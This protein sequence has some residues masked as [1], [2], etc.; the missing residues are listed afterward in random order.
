MNK[1]AV[2]EATLE[3]LKIILKLNSDLF[4]SDFIHDDQLNLDWTYKEGKESFEKRIKDEDK[5]VLVAEIDGMIIGY[6]AGGIT[7]TESWRPIKRSELENIF[8]KENFRDKEVGTKLFEKFLNWSSRKGAKKL[9]VDTY[10]KN[11]KAVSFY[12]KMGFEL[13]SLVFEKD[14]S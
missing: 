8:I 3:D 12:E 11:E 10:A 7:K 13:K 9:F 2:R 4:D 5:L 14:I 1:L 6:L